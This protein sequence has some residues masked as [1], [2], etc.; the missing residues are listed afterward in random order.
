MRNYIE[1][2]GTDDKWANNVSCRKAYITDLCAYDAVYHKSCY[3]NFAS[4][5]NIPKTFS[6]GQVEHENTQGIGRPEKIET[7]VAFEKVIELIEETNSEQLTLTEVVNAME[8]ELQGTDCSVY[9]AQY[10][11]KKI[12]LVKR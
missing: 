7:Q 9:T 6:V 11:K 5:Y 12:I 1:K 4:G 8:K 10:M 2:R 3:S